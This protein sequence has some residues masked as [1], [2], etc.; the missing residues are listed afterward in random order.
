LREAGLCAGLVVLPATGLWEA[1]C[2]VKGIEEHF[3]EAD[4]IFGL[5][6]GN[7]YGDAEAKKIRS[8]FSPP[9]VFQSTLP[10]CEAMA[11]QILH[12]H[13]TTLVSS[14]ACPLSEPG[15]ARFL[16]ARLAWVALMEL[17]VELLWTLRGLRLE[18]F[19]PS[20]TPYSSRRKSLV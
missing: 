1:R 8:I 17:T 14:L 2:A 9:P 5:I 4:H 20:H 13:I 16:E 10:Y 18:E 3:D 7:R 19:S 11:D 12:G 6:I 15:Y